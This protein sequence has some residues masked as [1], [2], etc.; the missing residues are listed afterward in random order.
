MWGW[1]SL[2]PLYWAIIEKRSEDWYRGTMQVSERVLWMQKVPLHQVQLEVGKGAKVQFPGKIPRECRSHICMH[3]Q[4]LLA[5]A[6]ATAIK[7]AKDQKLPVDTLAF[8]DH[9][10]DSTSSGW[11]CRKTSWKYL[12]NHRKTGWQIYLM[13]AIFLHISAWTIV[14]SWHF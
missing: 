5:V 7:S 14:E 12:T 3:M 8:P 2:G 1:K 13:D 11:R 6:C 10:K 4:V 9:G